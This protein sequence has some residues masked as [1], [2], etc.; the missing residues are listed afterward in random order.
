LLSADAPI[1]FPQLHISSADL[2][3]ML[4]ETSG[5]RGTVDWDTFRLL[6]GLASWY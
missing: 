5:E 4:R 1:L 3:M 2:E 6:M